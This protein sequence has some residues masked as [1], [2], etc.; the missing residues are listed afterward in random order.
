[1]NRR[2]TYSYSTVEFNHVTCR[3]ID[4][5]KFIYFWL[6]CCTCVVP[7][8]KPRKPARKLKDRYRQE[9]KNVSSFP[10]IHNVSNDSRF[11]IIA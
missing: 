3:L 10:R 4:A 5:S 11:T 8:L 9:N 2:N 6:V 1:M 7:L